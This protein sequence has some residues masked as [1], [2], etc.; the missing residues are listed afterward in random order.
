MWWWFHGG[1]ALHKGRYHA[2]LK[3]SVCS[4]PFTVLGTYLVL[5]FT[6][7]CFCQVGCVLGTSEF[8]NIL[9]LIRGDDMH[10]NDLELRD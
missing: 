6:G 10:W 5:K 8:F 9:V 3:T 2:C 4:L 7:C 1:F